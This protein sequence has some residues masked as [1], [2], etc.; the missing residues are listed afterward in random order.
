MSKSS[1]LFSLI[2]SDVWGPS[3]IATMFRARWFVTFI[4]Y[5]TRIAWLYLLRNKDELFKVFQS[6]H[7]MIQTQF[8]AKLK[9]LRYNNSGKFM[10]L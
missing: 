6:F 4:N 1:I 9:V 8:S 2:H 7:A 3:S 5:C 10:N